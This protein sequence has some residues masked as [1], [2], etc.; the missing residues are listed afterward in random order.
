[1][2]ASP[3]SRSLPADGVRRLLRLA[4]ELRELSHSANAQRR[5]YLESV[6]EMVGAQFALLCEF[7][8]FGPGGKGLVVQG[9]DHGWTCAWERAHGLGTLAAEGGVS[10]PLARVMMDDHRPCA[11]LTHRRVEVVTD[12]AWY[13]SRFYRDYRQVGNLDDALYSTRPSPSGERTQGLGLSRPTGARRFSEEERDLIHFAHEEY[14]HL[15]G[16]PRLSA[17]EAEALSPRE[18]SVLDALLTGQSEKHMAAT[19]GLSPHTVHQH[20]TTIYRAFG[21]HSRAELMRACLAPSAPWA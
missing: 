18:R 20:V 16:R 5:H 8:D 13:A 17:P 10:D 21:V 7:E 9:I 12:E 19:L 3:S 15:M 6:C 11:V 4:G 14:G 2:R 1:M